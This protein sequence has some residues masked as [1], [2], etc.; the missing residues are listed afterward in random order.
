MFILE[1]DA[2]HG[3]SDPG[4]GGFGYQEK[5]DVLAFTLKVGAK[6]TAKYEIDVRYTRTTDV[7]VELKERSNISDRCGANFFIITKQ[8]HWS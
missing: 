1:L 6:L 2:G 4:A 8:C 5:N 7:F 3:G